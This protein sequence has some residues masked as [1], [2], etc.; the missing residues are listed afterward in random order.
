MNPKKKMKK[1]PPKMN[2][3]SFVT[4]SKVTIDSEPDN[5]HFDLIRPEVFFLVDSELEWDN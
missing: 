5:Q 4:K 1:D 3:G 2:S